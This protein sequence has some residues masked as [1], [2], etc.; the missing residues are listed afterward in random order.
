MSNLYNFLPARSISRY[1]TFLAIVNYAL[2][3][4]LTELVLAQLKKIQE[5]LQEWGASQEQ[6]RELYR[7]IRKIHQENGNTYDE[8]LCLALSFVISVSPFGRTAFLR[9]S[10]LFSSRVS[11]FRF[12]LSSSFSRLKAHKALIKLLATYEGA[13]ADSLSAVTKDA[14]EVI[15][16]AINLPDSYQYDHLLE[17]AAVKQLE[18]H[19]EHGATYELLRIFTADNLSAFEAFT[20]ANGGFLESKGES[21]RPLPIFSSSLASYSRSLMCLHSLLSLETPCVA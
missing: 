3:T 5:R 4:K 12:P 20:K 18:K 11:V 7:A 21:N 14:A 9:N 16:E 2:A 15:I 19:A 1:T 10:R 6:A 13:P 17:L 8:V